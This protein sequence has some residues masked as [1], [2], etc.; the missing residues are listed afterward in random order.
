LILLKNFLYR[1]RH[2]LVISLVFLIG[3]YFCLPKKIF[4]DPYCTVLND[5]N[6]KLL[7]ASIAAD[8]QWRFPYT[9][10]IPEKF[11][12]AL[13]LTE[14]KRF[15][16]HWGV[17]P[18]S[19][20]RA[21]RQNIAAGKVVSGGSTI[22]M[23]V[24]RLSRKNQS[25]TMVEKIIEVILA[26][27][28]EFRYSKKEILQLYA[29]H[30][31]FGGNVVGLEAAC[32]RF[33]G[34]TSSE[35]SWS[36][37]ALLAVLPNNPS[38]LHLG[39]NRVRLKEKRNRLLHRLAETGKI[40][41]LTLELSLAE[42][43]PEKPLALPKLAP[44][45]LTRA[46]MEGHGQQMIRST[47][48]L[49]IQQRCGQIIHDHHQRL[50]GNQVNNAAVLVME[51]ETGHV[52]AYV[53]NTDSGKENDEEVDMI[54]APRSTGSILKPFLYAAMLKEGK[55]LPHTLYPDV[56]TF[57][58]GYSPKNFSKDFDGAVPAS[59]ALIRSLNIPIVHELRDY[60]FEKF[61]G[62]LKN[63]GLTTLSDQPSR[64]GLTLILGG[65]EGKLWDIT[66]AF[67]SM[68]RT[69][70]HYFEHPGKTR[71]K[72]SDFH[73]PVYEFKKEKNEEELDETSWLSAASIF[74]T[75]ET[76]KE[77]YRPGEGSG[78]KY[79]SS[80]KKIAWKTGTSF[81]FRDGWAV[82]V[83]PKYA[84]GV[85]VGNA[86]GEGRPG[87]T[88]TETAAPI[89]FD[90]FSSLPG[91]EWFRQP[92]SEMVQVATCTQSGHRATERCSA[93]D[94]IWIAR[95][96]L[97]TKPCPYHKK[98]FLTADKKQRVNTSCE[99]VANMVTENWFV[100]PAVQEYYFKKKNFSYQSLPPL[101][102]GCENPNTVAGLDIIYP[103]GDSKIFI[104]R[105]LDG[106]LGHA[107]FEATHRNANA[108]LYW[109]LDNTYLGFTIKNHRLPVTP[110]HGKHT[111][112]ILDENGESV[113]RTFD[114][115]SR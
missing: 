49:Y 71:Y 1:Y 48:D 62:L 43:I 35:L 110:S 37:A 64:Y 59:D 32:W 3:Y 51:V 75:F 46:A 67:A 101:R 107:L 87:L 41:P 39:K 19:M 36:E 68:A 94:T 79:F 102:A 12:E 108:I 78:W 105:E 16:H 83:N 47:L 76:L 44:H 85:W 80:A 40:D 104:P 58:N 56:P 14:D 17:D 73:P 92:V 34:R 93:T 96:G 20:A 28:L 103:K 18:M 53:G 114:V 55:M 31:P 113:S 106:S 5:R 115:V 69:L 23:Q 63:I 57:I 82:G 74:Q 90:V 95:P 27:R 8:G 25:R 2:W 15:Y 66:G 112:L 109:H 24:I 52:L 29:A 61:H 97:E 26:T 88:G 9:G 30:A 54:N 7:S 65:A 10:E 45:L 4:R 111:L 33:F 81:G 100:L 72:K 13:L 6:G 22:T 21:I 38:L 77:V 91:N 70:N 11:S 89:L 99:T 98:I 60:R 84:V 86:D 42:E 50:K